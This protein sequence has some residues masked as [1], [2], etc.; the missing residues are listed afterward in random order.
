MLK[1]LAISRLL[2]RPHNASIAE[3]GRIRETSP[4]GNGEHATLVP[5]E[6]EPFHLR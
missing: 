1:T 4:R 3:S 5:K 6:V 2:K